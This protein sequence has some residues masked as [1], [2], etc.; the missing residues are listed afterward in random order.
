MTAIVPW[1]KTTLNVLWRVILFYFTWALFLALLF[2]PFGTAISRWFLVSPV[3]A[4][5]YGD[6][7]TALTLLFA[8]WM[9]TR[10]IDH[11][12]FIT[13][14][15][16]IDN[17]PKDFLIG[18]CTGCCWLAASAGIALACGWLMPVS[19]LG[20]SWL[21]LTGSGVAMLFNVTAQELLLCGFIFQTIRDRSNVTIAVIISAALFSGYHAGAFNGEWLPVV[22]VFTA[23]ILFCL[24]YLITGNLWFPIAVHFAWDVL[25]GPVLGLT[26]SGKND[27]GGSWKM[28]VVNTSNIYTGG[29]FGL[30]GGLIVTIT[31]MVLIVSI[32]FLKRKKIQELFLNN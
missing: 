31:T 32:Y 22:N 28:L 2:V 30:E 4:R 26:E 8:T 14:G 10:F 27:L 21:V 3:E 13:I 29:V 24:A 11:R 18:L 16:A 7:A 15:L 9:M 17:F 1:L 12:P 6:S 25:L 23:G 5:L 19:P 20:F